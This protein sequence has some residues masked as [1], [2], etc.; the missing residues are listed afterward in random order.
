MG[1]F[2]VGTTDIRAAIIAVV[3]GIIILVKP[4]IVA[5]LAGA[6]LLFIGIMF[7]VLNFIPIMD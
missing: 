2:G 4:R 3:L 1:F 6:Y 7:L 5:Y